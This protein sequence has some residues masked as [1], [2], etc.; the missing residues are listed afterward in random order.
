MNTNEKNLEEFRKQYKSLEEENNTFKEIIKFKNSNK[1]NLPKEK[2][3][4]EQ[5][6]EINDAKL[7]EKVN[8]TNIFFN[9]NQK[10]KSYLSNEIEDNE[11]SLSNIDVYI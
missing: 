4:N 2:V 9:P 7:E 5:I 11:N 10:E 6:N 8:S 1:Q 3:G